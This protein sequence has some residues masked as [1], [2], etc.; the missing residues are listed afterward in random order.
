MFDKQATFD[1]HARRVYESVWKCKYQLM[2]YSTATLC[3]SWL[4]NT[5]TDGPFQ[6]IG[7]N[8]NEGPRLSWWAIAGIEAVPRTPA[9]TLLLLAP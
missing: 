1:W 7:E 4:P 3:H 2:T 6:V 9:A 8:V 5:Y